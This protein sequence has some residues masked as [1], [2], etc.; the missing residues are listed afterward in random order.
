MKIEMLNDYILVQKFDKLKTNKIS[1]GPFE[2]RTNTNLGIITHSKL[3]H[4]FIKEGTLVYYSKDYEQIII[5][6]VELMA[7]KL[8]NILAAEVN[9]S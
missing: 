7:M 3:N 2:I 4:P 8:S 9:E 1:S 5:G 6:G